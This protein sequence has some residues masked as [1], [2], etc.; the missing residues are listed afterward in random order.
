MRSPTSLTDLGAEKFNVPAI[1]RIIDAEAK[2]AY[3]GSERT[4]IEL[5]ARLIRAQDAEIKRLRS[6]SDREGE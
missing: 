5:V 1:L 2:G 3:G 4:M 6:T